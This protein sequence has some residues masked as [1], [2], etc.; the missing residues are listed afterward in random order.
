MEAREDVLVVRVEGR[1]TLP[2]TQ[3]LKAFL[4]CIGSKATDSSG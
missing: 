2:P 3:P 4:T 1:D